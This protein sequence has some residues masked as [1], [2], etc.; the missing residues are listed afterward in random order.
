MIGNHTGM[1]IYSG[2]DAD[3]IDNSQLNPNDEITELA[4]ELK[5]PFNTTPDTSCAPSLYAA[6]DPD[7]AANRPSS[8]AR[9]SPSRT[10]GCTAA[11]RSG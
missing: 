6:A 1:T 9:R 10:T 7:A 5:A 8:A 2:L 3:A 11:S 4:L